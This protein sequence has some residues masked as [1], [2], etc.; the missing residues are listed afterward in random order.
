MLQQA[1]AALATPKP[2][3]QKGPPQR[4]KQVRDQHSPHM[5]ALQEAG[6]PALPLLPKIASHEICLLGEFL[7]D[8][9]R[10]L[11][12]RHGSRKSRLGH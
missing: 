3:A 12:G 9:H 5:P 7:V 6:L 2:P 11:H 10:G 1:A 4:N 8:M